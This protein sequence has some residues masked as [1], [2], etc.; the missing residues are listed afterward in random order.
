MTESETEYVLVT[1]YFH[2]DTASTGQL[3]TDLAVGLQDRGLD[4]TVYTG[5]PNYHSG[6]NRRQPTRSTHEGVDVRRIRAPQLRQSSFLR[7]GINWIV[8]TVWMVVRLLVSRQEG[9][10]ELVFVSNPPFLPVAMWA[11]CRLR[12]WEYTYIVYDLYPDFTVERGYV[13]EGG[14]V[15]TVWR[16]L[17]E[18]VFGEAKHVV[19]L[20]PVMKD[21]IVSSAGQHFDASKVAIIHNWEDGE[22]IRPREKSNNWFAQEHGT[23]APFTLLYSGNIGE[24]H[25]LK[26]VVEAVAR[27]DANLDV[28]LLII[29]EGDKKEEIV[30]LAES[31]G[32]RGSRVEFLPYQPLEDLPY[33]LTAGDVSI[34]TVQEGLEGVCVSSKLY[35]AMA[36]GMPILVVAQ[37]NDDEARIVRT[38]DAGINVRQGDADAVVDAIE[39]W[40]TTPSLVAKQ[41]ANAR[42]AFENQF[43]EERAIDRYYDLLADHRSVSPDTVS[44]ESEASATAARNVSR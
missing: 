41:G 43:T 34:V 14:L 23:V 13:R 3:M 1:E 10:R 39:T 37:P 21:R 30:G 15:E 17:N 25:D 24:N 19:A 7:R 4:M 11:V 9:E 5:Q 22:F 20:G 29:G 12:G 6:E 27:L 26:T 33:S 2:P 18:Y 44:Q 36:A 8:F 35:T 16:A 40:T 28:K 31:H 38:V 42:D 32:L